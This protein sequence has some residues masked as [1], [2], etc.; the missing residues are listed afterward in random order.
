M[1]KEYFKLNNKDEVAKFENYLSEYCK[2]RNNY[3]LSYIKL[4]NAFDFLK[5]KPQGGRIFTALLDIK[6]NLVLLDYDITRACATWNHTFAKDEL[7]GGTVLDSKDKF[8]AKMDIH[9]F[10]SS[11]VLRYRAMWD[12][13]MG[14]LI[15]I[16]SPADYDKFTHAKSK[17]SCFLKLVKN[18]KRQIPKECF[19]PLSEALTEFEKEFRTPEAHGTGSLRKWSFLMDNPNEN[20]CIKFLGLWNVLLFVLSEIDKIFKQD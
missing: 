5:N 2:T 6:I 16:F 11:F 14:L 9:R 7:Q 18:N 3:C 8:F 4:T 19:E 20:P 12:K 10:N 17:K 13:L 1:K 15:L